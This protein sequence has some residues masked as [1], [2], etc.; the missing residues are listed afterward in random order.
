[1]APIEAFSGDSELAAF[2]GRVCRVTGAPRLGPDE[3]AAVFEAV[4]DVV[5]ENGYQ[6]T[7]TPR[8]A[9]D[10]CVEQGYG[11]SRKSVLFVVRGVYH[12]GYRFQPSPVR[13]ETLA[14][15]FRRNV[16][17]LCFAVQLELTDEDAQL[18]DRWFGPESVPDSGID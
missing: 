16:E 14:R 12:A 15:F 2:A 5:E 9:R 6:Y 17:N 8:L 11:V 7:I 13:A 10:R 4:A 3:Y 1:V 18:L